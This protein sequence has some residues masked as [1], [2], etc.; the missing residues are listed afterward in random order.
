MFLLDSK[1]YN[2]R[3]LLRIHLAAHGGE[4]FH[5]TGALGQSESD[6]AQTADLGSVCLQELWHVVAV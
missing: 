3:S 1:L 5:E 6:E 4:A 2:E